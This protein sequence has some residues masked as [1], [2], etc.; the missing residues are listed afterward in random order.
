GAVAHH[1]GEVALSA[2]LPDESSGVP[3]GAVGETAHFQQHHVALAEG[4]EVVCDGTADGAS[5]DDENSCVVVAHRVS[6]RVEPEL[7]ELIGLAFAPCLRPTGRRIP[8][9][10]TPGGGAPSDASRVPGWNEQCV[11]GCLPC[12]TAVFIP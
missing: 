4:C 7:L 1:S 8:A 3:G 10:H 9:A 6:S 2:Q 11:L 5:A 12:T